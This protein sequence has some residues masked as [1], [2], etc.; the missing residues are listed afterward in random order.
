MQSLRRNLTTAVAVPNPAAGAYV[1]PHSPLAVGT[2]ATL[3]NGALRVTPWLLRTSVSISRIGSEVTVVGDAGSKLRLGIY[4]DTGN[5]Y[6]GALV[7]DAGQI[8]GDSATVQELTVAVTLRA[9]L[10]W[11]GGVVQAVTTTQP[12]VRTQ[13]GG[14]LDVLLSPGTSLPSAGSTVAG[15]NQT[16]VTGALPA[17]FSSTVAPV[18]SAPR[19][20]VKLA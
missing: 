4:A 9:G 16:G 17:T 2:S 5:A 6:P 11:I 1:Y 18:A 7:V 8:A 3:S 13:S 20:F 15:Y 10:Y 14:N 19:L 12:T